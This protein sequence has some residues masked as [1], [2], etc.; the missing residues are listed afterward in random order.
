MGGS[1]VEFGGH[2]ILEPEAHGRLVFF[3]PHMFDFKES[4][5]VLLENKAAIQVKDKEELI[6]KMRFFLSDLSLA[7]KYSNKARTVLEKNQGATYRII[8]LLKKA[9]N[10]RCWNLSD[11]KFGK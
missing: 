11:N 5:R 9:Q 2:N 6:E 7:E 4:A 3:G 8:N 10:L 1:L